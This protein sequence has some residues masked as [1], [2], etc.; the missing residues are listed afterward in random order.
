MSSSETSEKLPDWPEELRPGAV[1]EVAEGVRRLVAPNP[2]IMTGPG[3][4]TYL[5]GKD[6][7]VVVDPGPDDDAHLEA[8]LAASGGRIRQILVT[9]T[10]VDH[11]PLATRL[12]QASGAPVLAQGPAPAQQTPGLD[13]HE[14]GFVPDRVVVDG[15]VIQVGGRGLSVVGTPGHAANHLCF[16]LDGLLFSG[17]HVM[18]GS[19]VVICPP[20]GDMA[21]YLE[22]LGRV[23]RRLPRRI[24]PG[25]GAMID[26]PLAVLDDYL[27]HRRHREQEVADALVLAGGQGITPED[28]VALIYQ[29]VKPELHPI[30]RYSV[31]AHL[32]H[33]AAQG[34]AVAADAEQFDAPW[35]TPDQAPPS[36][37]ETSTPDPIASRP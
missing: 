30:A 5:L 9:H 31:W 20:D 6:D 37:A 21:E 1:I 14:M 28:L 22:S 26:D 27:A 25:H 36:A 35:W 33:L 34:R 7:L 19:T 32:R 18:S 11:S 29:A 24:A 10:H 12:K 23:R 17:D 16:D 2:G 4:N 8:I 3:T 13:S 15:D